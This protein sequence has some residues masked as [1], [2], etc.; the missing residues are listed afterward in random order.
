[1]KEI[2]KASFLLA[3]GKT[4]PNAGRSKPKPIRLFRISSAL[5]TRASLCAERVGSINGLFES[6]NGTIVSLKKSGIVEAS[7]T[8]SEVKRPRTAIN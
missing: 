1:M 4:K 2:P 7:S 6:V 3:I 8:T 5:V